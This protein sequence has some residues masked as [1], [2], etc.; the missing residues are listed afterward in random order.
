MLPLYVIVEFMERGDLKNYLTKCRPV[1]GHPRKLKPVDV[2]ISFL[3]VC[4]CIY[5]VQRLFL[6]T[7]FPFTQLTRMGNDVAAGM[8]FFES[9]KFVHRDLVS[10]CNINMYM[11]VRS[12]SQPL[13]GRQK[14]PCQQQQHSENR[15]FRHVPQHP[16]ARLL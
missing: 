3:C 13:L 10:V 15:G 14:L 6:L 11:C 1:A 12:E 7:I 9:E 5:Y 8:A 16:R 4:L 2:S